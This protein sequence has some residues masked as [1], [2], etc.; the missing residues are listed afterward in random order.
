MQIQALIGGFSQLH[1]ELEKRQGESGLQ[2]W[3]LSHE[4]GNLVPSTSDGAGLQYQCC[5]STGQEG[6]NG[7]PPLGL[8]DTRP[9]H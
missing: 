2:A 4:D 7:C 8:E 6:M 3:L 5:R 1:T 9:G